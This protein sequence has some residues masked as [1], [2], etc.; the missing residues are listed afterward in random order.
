[1][2]KKFLHSVKTTQRKPKI[3]RR[4]LSNESYLFPEKKEKSPSF[5]QKIYKINPETQ[6]T[7]KKDN[8]KP[9]KKAISLE[10]IFQKPKTKKTTC[11]FRRITNPK[12]P[13]SKRTIEP[14]EVTKNRIKLS[15]PSRIFHVFNTIQWLRKKFSE[16]MI[17]KSIYSLLPNNGKPVIP[18]DES[19]EDKRHRKMIEYLESLKG[20]MGREK[21]CNINP[22][23]FFNRTTF[24]T[25]LKLKK[26]FLE[27]DADGNRRMELD[28]MLEM[29][30]S[31]K[32]SANINDLVELFF[33]GKKFKEKEVMKLYLN[34]HQFMNFALTKDQDFR[35][36]MRNIKER[37]E[38]NNNNDLTKEDNDNSGEK[39]GYFP[40]TF[41]SLLDYFVDKGKE[42][43]SKIIINKAIEEM[44]E[45]INKKKELNY[46]NNSINI[47]NSV[48]VSKKINNQRTVKSNAGDSTNSI[49]TINNKGITNVKTMP[50]ISSKPMKKESGSKIRLNSSAKQINLFETEG[51]M[52]CNLEDDIEIDYEKQLKDIN[53]NK[54]IEEFSNLFQIV[55]INTPKNNNNNDNKNKIINKKTINNKNSDNKN[56]NIKI[57]NKAKSEQNIFKKMEQIN[58]NNDN[59]KKKIMVKKRS[60]INS[61]STRSQDNIK[62]KNYVSSTTK[63]ELT[64]SIYNSQNK[65]SELFTK[66]YQIIKKNNKHLPLNHQESS[67][68]I[69]N[70]IDQNIRSNR[71][72]DSKNIK[73]IKYLH[74]FNHQSNNPT[75]DR[76]KPLNN[77]K[78]DLPTLHHNNSLFDLKV[79]K[80]IFFNHNNNNNN[81]NKIIPLLPLQKT[82]I[83][84]DILD[85][86]L[87]NRNKNYN[88]KLNKKFRINYYGGKINM[89]NNY[90]D[91]TLRSSPK[92]DYV[93]F[94]FLSDSIQDKTHSENIININKI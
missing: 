10:H 7:S 28:E 50:S 74:Y 51:L 5:Y 56:N 37:V 9:K 88:N 61:V 93:P 84:Y 36:F 64:S 62:N 83:R 53:F 11:Q 17:N 30:E 79:K 27:F 4:L 77:S 8:E 90:N 59:E 86:G 60:L 43:N 33:K 87:S 48:G 2:L 69:R 67:Q 20:P 23:Y 80:N 47:N 16:D 58:N 13:F 89:F 25:I 75:I 66:E 35:Q 1:M 55:Q 3:K 63:G 91:K 52:D 45:I 32:I 92:L 72:Y 44:N 29:F 94:K 6:N 68:K 71:Y 14:K 85:K 70:L 76:D 24:D 78:K 21:F 26:I 57:L 15:K 40:M 73:K 18:E 49:P 34:F 38:K 82:K 39:G 12:L 81:N 31:N 41:K 54:I 22:K 42:R 19:E 46:H 65:K